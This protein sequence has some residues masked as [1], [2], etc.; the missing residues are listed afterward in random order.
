MKL[1]FLAS[2]AKIEQT[3]FDCKPCVTPLFS[4]PMRPSHYAHANNDE[5]FDKIQQ[6]PMLVRVP[7]SGGGSM[8]FNASKTNPLL[9][10]FF[11]NLPTNANYRQVQS[12][13]PTTPKTNTKDPNGHTD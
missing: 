4:R 9:D 7:M 10:N 13:T 8:T 12:T 5:S 11:K 6:S 2:D 1:R 3:K